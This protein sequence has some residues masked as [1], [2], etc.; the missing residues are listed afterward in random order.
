MRC[1]VPGKT[2]RSIFQLQAIL[3]LGEK[4]PDVRALVGPSLLHLRCLS[5]DSC[6]EAGK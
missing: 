4:G 2:S 5:L 1:H 6:H 3:E